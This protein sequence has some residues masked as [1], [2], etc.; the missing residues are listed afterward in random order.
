MRV[1]FLVVLVL[2]LANLSFAMYCVD[3][4]DNST[5][6]GVVQGDMADG[7]TINGSTNICPGTYDFSGVTAITVT[8]P[9]VSIGCIRSTL[10]GDNTTGT[11]GIYTDQFN[12]TI[13]D[14]DIS[15]FSTG[16]YVDQAPNGTISDTNISTTHAVYTE[17][18]GTGIFLYRGADYE[19]IKNCDVT[20]SEFAG[21]LLDTDSNDTIAN[22]TSVSD[23][24]DAI[25]LESSTNNTIINSSGTSDTQ[26]GIYMYASSNNTI[27]N[28]SGIST[29]TGTGI[30]IYQS[31][32]NTIIDSTGIADSNKGID[33][34]SGSSG[35]MIINSTGTSSSDN[36]IFLSTDSDNNEIVNSTGASTTGTGIYIESSYN[37]TIANSTGAS[38][39]YFGIQFLGSNSTIIGSAGTS[40]SGQGMLL[41]GSYNQ[42]IGSAGTSNGNTGIH[43][44]EAQYGTIVNS[45]ASS[46][47]SMGMYVNAASTGNTIIGSNLT[48][49]YGIAVF[50]YEVDNNTISG[51]LISCYSSDTLEMEGDSENNTIANSTING[52]G[53][54]DIYLDDLGSGNVFINNTLLNGSTL[55]EAYGSGD[56]FCWNNFTQTSGYYAQGSGLEYFNSSLC[57]GEGNI[58]ANVISGQAM[59]NGT[60]PSSGFP[61]LFIG[62]TTYDDANSLGKVTGVSDYA[63]LT[64]NAVYTAPSFNLTEGDIPATLDQEGSTYYLQGDLTGDATPITITAD[65]VTLDCNGHSI[66]FAQSSNGDGIDVNADSATIENCTITNDGSQYG[67]AGISLSSYN[68][69]VVQNDTISVTRGGGDWSWVM[70]ISFTGSN[71]SITG[72]PISVDSLYGFVWAVGINMAGADNTIVN[73]TISSPSN[74]EVECVGVIIQSVS[75][76]TFSGN[77]ITDPG[78]WNGDDWGVLTWGASDNNQFHGNKVNSEIDIIIDGSGNTFLHNNLTGS[79]WVDDQSGGN[80]YNDSTSGNIYYDSGGTPSWQVYDIKDVN[81]DS[82]ADMGSD[83]PFSSSLSEG[84]WQ[85]NG[86]DWHPFTL[87]LGSPFGIQQL[88]ISPASP[89]ITGDLSCDLLAY[90]VDN[91]S[92]VN[93]TYQWF[94]NGNLTFSG[95]YTNLTLGSNT[96]LSTV[97]SGNLTTGDSWLCSA[98][99][100]FDAANNSGWVNSSA[101]Q[102]SQ[103]G[104][105]ITTPN[106]VYTFTSDSTSSG[107]CVDVDADNVTIDC[108][109]HSI[110]GTGGTNGVWSGSSGTVVENCT[111]SD[112]AY[113]VSFEDVDGGVIKNS[114]MNSNDLAGILLLDSTGDNV[115]DNLLYEN[116]AEAGLYLSGSTNSTITG[117]YFEDNDQGIY[118]DSGS[119][120]NSMANNSFVNNYDGVLFEDS[121]TTTTCSTAASMRTTTASS[122]TARTTTSSGTTRSRIRS[123]AISDTHRA[124][125]YTPGTAQDTAS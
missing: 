38:D 118:L 45:T 61:T 96:S 105:D 65:D 76:S 119:D 93:V 16:V 50:F 56:I 86:Q 124:R 19:T 64:A 54:T 79:R 21:I 20:S 7:F 123:R 3:F 99:V 112:F 30:N 68:D 73:N 69:N 8:Q 6:H 94:K 80:N 23:P 109:G 10:I 41:E 2:V 114:D 37:D 117:N 34:Y 91:A 24:G 78:C 33:L 46:A 106:T 66:I 77:S 87:V 27:M 71:N 81:N 98:Y 102:I 11:S 97:A 110:T 89:S 32:N 84:E 28:S 75:N 85:E 101:V 44:F 42:V 17:A 83:L 57:N 15:N 48:C 59:I 4:T 13:E 125:S 107:D 51:S 52:M 22:S 43:L 100:Q 104:V 18:D 31:T 74:P 116:Y 36:G 111:F 62:N 12:T 5:Y 88:A 60:T 82:W 49:N 25:F 95:N 39:S 40:D 55:A 53:G 29:S 1:N 35:N 113:G 90:D 120:Y 121:S 108:E 14:C 115:Y 122:S 63:P 103:C 26:V 72:T 70:G 9:D 58:W 67:Q 47:S 92:S